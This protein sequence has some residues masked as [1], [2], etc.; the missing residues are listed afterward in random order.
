[1]SA[2][3]ITGANRGIG[4]EFARQY[5][6]DGWE[7]FAACR[8]PS[9]ARQLQEMA[10][11]STGRLTTIP[12][13]VTKGESGR[14]AAKQLVTVVIDLLINNAGT[15]GVPGQRTGA[16]DYEN[17][18]RVLDVNT[19]GPLRVIEAFMDQIARSQRRLIVTITSGMGSLT[20]NTSG[21]SIAYR[22]SKAA[23]NMAMRSVAADLASRRI[24]CIVVN[25]G[26]VKTAMGGA[27]APLT[28]E[29][30]VAAMRRLIEKVGPEHSG[31]FF[32]YDGSEY[33]W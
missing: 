9:A 23:V 33:P 26:W 8:A 29:E 2:V 13:D 1:M 3:L 32:N 7:V 6:A 18:V 10:R 16:V 4:L 5:T 12:M 30:S 22:T 31:K 20:D 11:G 21:G 19:M 17:W 14:S 28:P 25:P 15:A 24:A 27:G